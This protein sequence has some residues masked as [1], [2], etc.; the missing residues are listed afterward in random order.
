M[1]QKKKSVKKPSPKTS[2]KKNVT[3]SK[4]LPI[5]KKQGTSKKKTEQTTLKGGPI[6]KASKKS[7]QKEPNFVDDSLL[8]HAFVSKPKSVNNIQGS[9]SLFAVPVPVIAPKKTPSPKKPSPKKP[10]PKK[11]SPKQ[12]SAKTPSPKKPSPKKP[13]PKKTSPKKPSPKKPSPKKPRFTGFKADDPKSVDLSQHCTKCNPESETTDPDTLKFRKILEKELKQDRVSIDGT[14]LT[15]EA[16]EQTLQLFLKNVALNSCVHFMVQDPKSTTLVVETTPYNLLCVIN[17]VKELME[18]NHPIVSPFGNH[19]LVYG[20]EIDIATPCEILKKA[21]TRASIIELLKKKTKMSRLKLEE[22][23]KADLCAAA[24]EISLQSVVESY[25]KEYEEI[26]TA[27]NLRTKAEIDKQNGFMYKIYRVAD[28]LGIKHDATM[29][30]TFT[31]KNSRVK[32]GADNVLA[33]KIIK[34]LS[35]EFTKW[36]RL[37]K[38]AIGSAFV[39]GTV[40]LTAF[41]ANQGYLGATVQNYAQN[42]FVATSGKGAPAVPLSPPVKAAPTEGTKAASAGTKAPTEGTKAASAGTKAPTEASNLNESLN[43]IKSGNTGSGVKINQQNINLED[44]HV[45]NDSVLAPSNNKMYERLHSSEY[46]TSGYDILPDRN[47]W[48]EKQLE[49]ALNAH[50]HVL[51]RRKTLI[52][53]KQRLEDATVNQVSDYVNN[54][55]VHGRWNIFLPFFELPGKIWNSGR[56]SLQSYLKNRGFS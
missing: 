6:T 30:R 15:H 20:F 36:L 13:S 29:T 26:I 40:M 22:M 25:K 54:V 39:V 3:T 51:T 18:Q 41:A 56:A 16:A 37:K 23:R 9:A 24:S 55:N 14:E 31:P 47:Q 49:K 1:P 11:P 5:T 50:Q 7:L 28:S 21:H 19:R 12:P 48:E 44:Y 32:K 35:S 34:A 2:P 42:P 27:P 33:E 38:V 10:S 45:D 17:Y 52:D 8:G 46:D 53:L 43:I 4:S